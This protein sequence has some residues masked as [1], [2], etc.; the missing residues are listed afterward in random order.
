MLAFAR[1]VT[2]QAFEQETGWAFKPEGACKGDV[3]IPLRQPPGEVVDLEVISR[4]MGLPLVSEP[5]LNVWALGPESIG[6][7]ALVSA[8][9]PMLV[10]PDV[11][12]NLFD[13]ASLRGSKVL[14]YA[15]APY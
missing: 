4:E 13:L 14:L 11:D 12:G 7:R 2:K 6:A 10:L 8:Q 9:A 1:Q 15:W 5:E 3:C